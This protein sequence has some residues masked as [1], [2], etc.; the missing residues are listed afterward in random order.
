M[1]PLQEC[2][3]A[4]Q[5]TK[6]APLRMRISKADAAILKLSSSGR[7]KYQT[8]SPAATSNLKDLVILSSPWPRQHSILEMWGPRTEQ[9]G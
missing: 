6:T 9:V 2:R 8:M 7:H 1:A 3:L 5:W 4:K